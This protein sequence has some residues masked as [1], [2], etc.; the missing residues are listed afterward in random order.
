MDQRNSC[1]P[2]RV[3]EATN[4]PLNSGQFNFLQAI[5]RRVAQVSG[6]NMLGRRIDVY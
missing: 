3:S 1:V 5:R 2:E 4:D 6:G